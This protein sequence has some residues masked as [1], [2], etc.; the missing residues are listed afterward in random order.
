MNYDIRKKIKTQEENEKKLLKSFENFEYTEPPGGDEFIIK[1]TMLSKLIKELSNGENFFRIYYGNSG[2]GKTTALTYA[3]K[4]SN[5]I[6]SHFK[7][8]GIN[9]IEGEINLQLQTQNQNTVEVI[10]TLTHLKLIINKL[11][12]KNRKPVILLEDFVD[13]K[14]IESDNYE[15][16]IRILKELKNMS[17]RDLVTVIISLSTSKQS[18][19]DKLKRDIKL[20]ESQIVKF[21]G[22]NDSELRVMISGHDFLRRFN[23]RD[24]ITEQILMKM[25]QNMKGINTAIGFLQKSAL[26][27]NPT[28]FEISKEL[29]KADNPIIEDIL[30]S[31][32]SK[33]I[34]GEYALLIDYFLS[35]YEMVGEYNSTKLDNCLQKSQSFKD[36]LWRVET[37]KSP[38]FDDLNQI[39]PRGK[40]RDIFIS[41]SLV[42][43]ALPFAL[44]AWKTKN[45]D[46]DFDRL[47]RDSN[48]KRKYYL[49][50]NDEMQ[51]CMRKGSLN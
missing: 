21:G 13:F 17:K 32:E 10:S 15:K 51:K 30:S 12:E 24:L 3:M 14:N 4:E 29:E 47:R 20:S 18:N 44:I 42:D 49:L 40:K 46:I 22:P 33:N 35:S 8:R 7:L 26:P 38:T 6:L 23:N 11:H 1:S 34:D 31:I 2:I 39:D 28:K 36:W 48:K 25:G 5:R 50:S 16:T 19:I 43:K 41:N 45:N 27:S 9:D 37:N